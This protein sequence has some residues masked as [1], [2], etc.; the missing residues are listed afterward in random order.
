ML[1]TH[2]TCGLPALETVTVFLVILNVSLVDRQP[3]ILNSHSNIET[4]LTVILLM[5]VKKLFGEIIVPAP[6][7]L[8]YKPMPAIVLPIAVYE[9]VQ[10]LTSDPANALTDIFLV[11]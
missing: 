9:L 2:N 8:R 6:A 3:S 5:A 11:I 7:I 4:P 10:M 1:S